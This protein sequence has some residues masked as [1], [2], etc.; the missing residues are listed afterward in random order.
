[1]RSK[2]LL[3]LCLVI[4][5]QLSASDSLITVLLKRVAAL[6]VKQYDAFP[7]GAFPSYRSYAYNQHVE[8]ADI[9]PFYTGLIVFTL[10][11]LQKDW[12]PEQQAIVANITRQAL[13]MFSKFESR[14]HPH[15]YNFWPTD[16][17][18]VFPNGGWL[19]WF[20]R[21][22]SLANDLDDTVIM[23]LAMNSDA[24]TAAYVHDFMQAYINT[25]QKRIVNTKKYLA[26]FGAYSTWFGV[27][28]PIDFDV[29]ALSNVLYFVQEYQLKWTAAD[30]AS[31]QVLVHAIDQN[32][33]LNDGAFISPHYEKPA[34]I[35]YHLAR[36]MSIKPIPL[37]EERK[38]L[39]I[40]QA[41]TLLQKSSS[42]IESIILST[43]LVKW[44]EDPE[45]LKQIKVR[46]LVKD[47]ESTDFSFFNANMATFL[48][49]PW[50]RGLGASR[51]GYFSYFCPAYN[52][53]LLLEL[54]TLSRKHR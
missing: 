29:C 9:N 20:D 3:L 6:Q 43:A 51:I 38:P 1:M 21:K 13:P 40:Q 42:S 8:K 45:S 17:V 10:Q 26:G 27:K 15:I 54:L 22:H 11:R 37:L 34:V 46:S 39:L 2:Y 4:S 52:N 36:L 41:K 24:A 32:D 44:G 12:N 49:A 53:V 16:T 47:I 50:K 5:L 31:L 14:K 33:H 19:N 30:S 23:L 7:A 18:K 25:P 28:M 48:P 35:L